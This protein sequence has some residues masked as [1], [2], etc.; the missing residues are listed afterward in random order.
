MVQNRRSECH[1]GEVWRNDHSLHL[2]QRQSFLYAL[3]RQSSFLHSNSCR[4]YVQKLRHSAHKNPRPNHGFVWQF[5]W[6]CY[7]HPTM[8]ELTSPPKKLIAAMMTD[9]LAVAEPKHRDI[10][11]VIRRHLSGTHF[12]FPTSAEL[13]AAY[14][15][16]EASRPVHEA[17]E[18]AL[19]GKKVRTDSGVAPITLLTKPYACPGKCVYCPTEVRMPKSYVASE[20]AAA[21]ALRLN[22]DPYL[23][24]VKRVQSMEANGHEAKKIELIIKGGTWSAYPWVYRKWFVKRC[25]DAANH[26]GQKKRERFPKIEDSQRFNETAL[27]RIIGLTI[28]TRPDWVTP[29]EVIRLRMLGCTRVELGVQAL[30]DKILELTKRGHDINAVTH[31]TILLKAAAFKTDYHFMPGQPGSTAQRDV[32]MFS[33]M[34]DNPRFRPDMVKIYPCVVIPSAELAEWHK[35]GEFKPLEGEELVETM[36]RMK[37]CIPYYCRIS[38]LIRDFP[39]NEISGGNLVTNL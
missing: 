23:Q 27:Y 8:S 29:Q 20:P 17:L 3:V 32:E 26:L 5:H 1:R 4:V 12:R 15:S 34:F 33:E 28:E 19:R 9:M 39:S 22:F 35:R 11:L 36:I 21:R 30:D 6:S 13:V 2:H 24:V 10:D 25:F 38:R 18:Q 31:A 37:T 7:H 16:T 14:R